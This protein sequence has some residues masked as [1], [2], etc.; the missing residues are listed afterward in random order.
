[1]HNFNKLFALFSVGEEAMLAND[2][3]GLKLSTIKWPTWIRQYRHQIEYYQRR[4]QNPRR[5]HSQK[6]TPIQI[7][8]S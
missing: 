5:V 1:M 2:K 6:A 4:H 3:D 7:V 8:Q